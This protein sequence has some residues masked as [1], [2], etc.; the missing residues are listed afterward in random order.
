MNPDEIRKLRFD[1]KAT[2]RQ[3]AIMVGLKGV[4]GARK[5]RR[6]E[7]GE[8]NP[9]KKSLEIMKEMAGKS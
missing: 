5:V 6:W 7:D 8:S 9:N 2:A 1:L 3:F 4:H